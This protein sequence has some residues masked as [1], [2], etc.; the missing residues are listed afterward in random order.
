MCPLRAQEATVPVFVPSR[1]G[2]SLD[3][4][5]RIAKIVVEDALAQFERP[6]VM[7]TGGKDSTLM[8]WTVRSVCQV[9]GVQV[10][11]ILF[12]DHGTHFEETWRLLEQ[13]ASSWGLQSIVARNDDILSRSPAPGSLIRVKD[14]SP[15]NQEEVI[16][17]ESADRT[18]PYALGNLVANHLLKTVPM[19]DAI[20][21]YGFDCV[22]TGIRWDE[23][24][25][26]SR[27][28]FVSPR[29]NPPH[30][31]VHPILHFAEREVWMETLRL[32][33][34]RH[35]LYDRGYRSFD[36]KHDSKK[37]GDLP[38]WQQDFDAVPERFG[39]AQDKEQIMERLRDLGYM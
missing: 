37:V 28:R 12:I 3:A 17:T 7:W 34:P 33:L 29:A 11:P 32:S 18:F 5:I 27:E 8:L 6:V 14:L 19:N 16:R 1:E 35:P 4:K 31:R 25:A 36:G 22:F 38:A 2:L 39:R 26:R 15:A 30:V 23:D 13:V 9:R 20:R 21:K 24:E 10:P